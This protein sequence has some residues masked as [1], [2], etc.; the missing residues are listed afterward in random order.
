MISSVPVSPDKPGFRPEISDA[1]GAR[2]VC[3]LASAWQ[4]RN[5]LIPTRVDLDRCEGRKR[6][7]VEKNQNSCAL[8]CALQR[9]EA[10]TNKKVFGSFLKNNQYRPDLKLTHD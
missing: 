4:R 3:G 8:P 2:R 1:Y 6:F 7:F 9:R 10:I 5:L